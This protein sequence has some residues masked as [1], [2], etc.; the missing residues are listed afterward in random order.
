MTEVD[1]IPELPFLE[2]EYEQQ[3]LN[4]S[5]IANPLASKKTTKKLLKV[6]KKASKTSQIKRGVKE[7]VKGL[8]K[9]AKGL[10]LIA[11]DVYPIDV[12]S[13][14]PVLCEENNV[15]YCYIPSKDELGM[16]GNTKRPTSVL[17]LT[18]PTE[19]DYND[20]YNECQ[21]LVKEMNE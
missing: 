13:H 15:N 1:D 17:M 18:I 11:G 21:E 9:G 7:V 5:E 14:L 8:R 2:Q 6:V 3:I 10:V 4:V 19:G 12:V 20:I 16:A